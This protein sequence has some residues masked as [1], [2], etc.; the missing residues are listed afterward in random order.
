MCIAWMARLHRKTL[1]P[2]W[3]EAC[4]QEV[5]GSGDTV[6]SRQAHFFHQAV[7]QGPEQS[8]DA[9]FGLGTVGRNPFDSQFT[10]GASELRERF[11]SAQLLLQ[12]SGAAAMAKDA[13]LIG[14]MRQRPSVAF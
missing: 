12:C 14:V 13:V 11:F 2:L 3:Q 9:P 6:D 1:C 5:V 7:L 8:L 4:F 10:Q